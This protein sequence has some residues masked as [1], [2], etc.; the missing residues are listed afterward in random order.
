M[1]DSSS[2]QQKTR[3]ASLDFDEWIAV[4]VAF[5]TI[6]MI[7][8]WAMGKKNDWLN[9]P[10]WQRLSSPSTSAPIQ[11]LVVQP[12]TPTGTVISPETV[13]TPT[14]TTSEFSSPRVPASPSPNTRILPLP[15]IKTSPNLTAGQLS[16][17]EATTG[18]LELP[19]TQVVPEKTPLPLTPPTATPTSAVKFSDVPDS[20][21]ASP[22]IQSLAATY[23]VAG[24]PDGTFKPNQPL[25]RAQLAVQLEKVF[26]QESKLNATNFQDVTNDFWA[27]NSIKEVSK[28]GFLRGYPG[29][30]FRPEQP[31]SRLQVL[32]ALASGLEL[33]PPATPAKTIEI[34]QDREQVPQ[35]AIPKIAAATE[36]GIVV[37][38]PNRELLNP[39]QTAT[40]AE[41]AAMVYQALVKLGKAENRSSEYVVSPPKNN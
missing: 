37:N 12:T 19:K 22:F 18:T 27:S 33:K 41:V 16:S 32:I 2:D 7:L 9:L 20:Y 29:D 40:R 8:Y 38:H 23:M 26:D 1:S 28:S 30:V 4:I 15:L 5:T 31:V 14:R 13:T 35:W 24:F 34:F 11:P 17:P 25:T 39:N 21:W 3:K 10:N 36:A 6:G